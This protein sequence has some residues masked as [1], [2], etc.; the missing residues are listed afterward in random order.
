LVHEFVRQQA[1]GGLG[2]QVARQVV[3]ASLTPTTLQHLEP[4]DWLALREVIATLEL[5]AAPSEAA[6]LG[7]VSHP[8]ASDGSHT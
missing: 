4:D 2:H 5:L 8:P 7:N 1:P 3:R 6:A